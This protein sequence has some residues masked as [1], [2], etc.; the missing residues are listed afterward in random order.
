MVIA[1][2][3]HGFNNG[4]MIES[5]NLREGNSGMNDSSEN[6]TFLDLVTERQSDRSY[7]RSKVEKEKL[8]R[9]IEAARLAP[10]ACNSQPWKFYVISE[11]DLKL[12]VAEATLQKGTNMNRFA[13]EAPVLAVM[14]VTK[15][16]WRTKMG[17]MM[18]GLP[19]YMIDAGIAAEHFCLQ[20][21]EE[22]LGSCMMGW[23]KEKAIRSCLK[24]SVEENV[25]L[26]IALGY[27]Q[28]PQIRKKHR[29]T[30][31]TIS[32]FYE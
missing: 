10:S 12:K 18:R 23:F 9:C 15:G 31:E 28:Q 24:L 11:P 14:T 27:R 8:L 4:I 17:Q 5:V 22:G 7:S 3:R 32:C 25:A 13:L 20:A 29:K 19:Y 26:V 16:N 1:V 30:V 21:T 6:N 2:N